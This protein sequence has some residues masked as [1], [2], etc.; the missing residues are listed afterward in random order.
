M[1]SRARFQLKASIHLTQYSIMVGVVLSLC[2]IG[3]LHEFWLVLPYLVWAG[4]VIGRW[5]WRY[6]WLKADTSVVAMSWTPHEFCCY[7]KNGQ[8]VQ[9]QLMA[10]SGFNLYF[11]TL[12]IAVAGGGQF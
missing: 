2:S 11:I 8:Q 7:L 3:V 4:G 10:K 5:L 6:V 1:L 9:G 12:Y